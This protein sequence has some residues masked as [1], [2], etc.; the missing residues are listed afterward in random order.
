MSFMQFLCFVIFDLYLYLY[1]LHY[2]YFKYMFMIYTLLFIRKSY[3]TQLV[4]TCK[5]TL[6]CEI[7]FH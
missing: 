2:S 5:N 4:I 1:Q 7:F 6:L 3:D